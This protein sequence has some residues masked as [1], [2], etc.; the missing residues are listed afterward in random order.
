MPYRFATIIGLILLA[1]SGASAHAV[2]VDARLAGDRVRVEA[3]FDDDTPARDAQVTVFDADRRIVAEGRTDEKGIWTF[4][5]PAPGKYGIALDAGDG[6]AAKT[7]ITIP[8][9]MLPNSPIRTDGPSRE[10]FTSPF[11]RIVWTIV[12]LAAISGLTILVRL[13]RRKAAP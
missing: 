10:E 9:Q 1:P 11:Q 5:T 7:T 2:G 3:Y 6:H 8:V 12:G 4:T 13:V